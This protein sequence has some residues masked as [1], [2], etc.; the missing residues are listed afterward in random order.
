[1]DFAEQS[2]GYELTWVSQEVAVQVRGNL[3]AYQ[4]DCVEVGGVW[5]L[6]EEHPDF[7]AELDT[8]EVGEISP[9]LAARS[10]ELGAVGSISLAS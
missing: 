9:E 4:G 7:D 10:P 1:M 3:W 8:P 6:G 5:Y 2:T